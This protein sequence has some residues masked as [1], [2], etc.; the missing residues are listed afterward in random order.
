MKTYEKERLQMHPSMLRF[1]LHSI[2]MW[3]LT[4]SLIHIL[5]FT[6]GMHGLT[7]KCPSGR[8]LIN[9]PPLTWFVI[10]QICYF[11]ALECGNLLVNTFKLHDPKLTQTNIEC[12]IRAI[13]LDFAPQH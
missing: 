6:F 7:Y 13:T 12:H 4:K 10:K 2:S 5:V 9:Y 8:S 1:M 3:Q 11:Q